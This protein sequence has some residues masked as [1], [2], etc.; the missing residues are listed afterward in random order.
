MSLDFQNVKYEL[1]LNTVAAIFRRLCVFVCVCQDGFADELTL[2]QHIYRTSVRETG[3]VPKQPRLIYAWNDR[4][5]DVVH[6]P[7]LGNNHW[8]SV[9][10]RS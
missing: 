8:Y 2:K 1:V 3:T 10:R 9:G 7:K 4:H 5:C 6:C